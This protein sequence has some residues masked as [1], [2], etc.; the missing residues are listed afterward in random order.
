MSRPEKTPV[1]DCI[2]AVVTTYLNATNLV[3]RIKRANNRPF[4]ED[5]LA[6]LEI[7]LALGPPIV[8]G[9][10]DLDVKRIGQKYVYGDETAQENMKSILSSLQT[11]LLVG[12]QRALMD[13]LDLDCDSLQASSDN[14]RVN[15]IVCLSQLGQRLGPS[16]PMS[17]VSILSPPAPGTV[18]MPAYG[19]LSDQESSRLSIAQSV[20]SGDTRSHTAP[21][22]PPTVDSENISTAGDVVSPTTTDRSASLLADRRCSLPPYMSTG[23]IELPVNESETVDGNRHRYSVSSVPNNRNNG[24]QY[25]IPTIREASGEE[26]LY[27]PSLMAPQSLGPRSFPTGVRPPGFEQQSQHTQYDSHNQR[28]KEASNRLGIAPQTQPTTPPSSPSSN[29]W[30]FKHRH[31]ASTPDDM[32]RTLSMS[33]VR[34]NFLPGLRRRPPS[35]SGSSGTTASIAENDNNTNT[36][37]LPNEENKYAGFCKGAWKMQT[38]T[39]KAMRAD[40][41]PSGMFS[42]ILFWRCTK[43]NFEGPMNLSSDNPLSTTMHAPSFSR[44]TPLDQPSRSFDHRVRVHQ[45]TG[46]RYRWAF[47]AKS[48]AY[49][50]KVPLTT[51]GSTCSYGCIY[52][53]SERRGPA[54]IFGN[55][56]S[57]MEHLRIHDGA[58][59]QG[60]VAMPE[61]ELL[62]RT[63]CLMERLAH[64]WEEFDINIPPVLAE[65][66]G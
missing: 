60:H 5:A 13:N 57:F 36:L 15:S 48:H 4:P 14:S 44:T 7:S 2:S 27:S 37:Y 56:D 52:C 10:Y 59:V 11:T 16:V 38:G 20:S 63:K 24:T 46:I 32:S 6:S 43:C 40:Q 8:Q 61:Q 26:L 9:Q 64:D 51:D 66:Q 29:M 47:L 49:C 17:K 23:T 45:A 35:M 39:Q 12:L 53:C 31:S 58:N 1:V 54:P 28:S 50:K 41:R 22:L 30:G 42:Q 18:E 34:S 25:P 55:V 19:D 21:S 3:E 62:N 33:N 65:V